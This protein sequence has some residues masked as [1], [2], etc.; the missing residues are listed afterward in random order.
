[1]TGHGLVIIITLE[2]DFGDALVVEGPYY[3][4]SSA[5]LEARGCQS[6]KGRSSPISE[7]EFVVYDTSRIVDF[8]DF[9]ILNSENPRCGKGHGVRNH[10]VSQPVGLG[11]VR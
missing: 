10:A 1:M 3:S 6:I 7:W 5:I 9:A 11:C 4:M 8:L 2:V